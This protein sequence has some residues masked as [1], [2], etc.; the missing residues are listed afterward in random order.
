MPALDKED[1][2]IVTNIA[3]QATEHAL[4]QAKRID[5]MDN[6]EFLAL[7]LEDLIWYFTPNTKQ[8]LIPVI[9]KK[10][11]TLYRWPTGFEREMKK[12]FDLPY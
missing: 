12:I 8:N 6:P 3:T 4:Y 11:L 2:T 10:V 1:M 5:A 9:A 7:E